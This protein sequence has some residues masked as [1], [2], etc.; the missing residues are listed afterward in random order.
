MRFSS[1]RSLNL[2]NKRGGGCGSLDASVPFCFTPGYILV[3]SYLHIYSCSI[4]N[5]STRNIRCKL[6]DSGQETD[7]DMS[8]L[9]HRSTPTYCI[10]RANLH[11]VRRS[12]H[13][14]VHL[15]THQRPSTRSAS[16]IS[17]L[18]HT[19]NLAARRLIRRTQ[20]LAASHPILRAVPLLTRCSI[21]GTRATIPHPSLRLIYPSP[22][23]NLKHN[24]E[25]HTIQY[26]TGLYRVH[27]PSMTRSHRGSLITTR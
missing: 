7:S 18:L 13:A 10:Y 12:A 27:L 5:L 8:D 1:S 19:T 23:D 9:Y 16:W 20:P 15:T 24:T 4:S 25:Q 14:Y 11:N 17:G 3:I 26:G 22:V 6:I 2:T 21:I